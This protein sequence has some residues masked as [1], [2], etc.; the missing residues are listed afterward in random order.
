MSKTIGVP[1]VD[2]TVGEPDETFTLT[3]SNPANAKLGT[4]Q[5][6]GTIENDDPAPRALRVGRRHG[7]A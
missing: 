3:L 1:I 5:A 2:D 7:H 4:A 6:I